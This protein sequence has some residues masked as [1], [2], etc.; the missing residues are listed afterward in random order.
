MHAHIAQHDCNINYAENGWHMHGHRAC[1]HENILQYIQTADQELKVD[2]Y[3][4]LLT[5]G[6][7]HFESLPQTTSH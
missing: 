4:K 6:S 5:A 3:F 1:V 7:G 2:I